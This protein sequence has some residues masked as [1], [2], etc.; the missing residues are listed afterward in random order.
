MEP[1]KW[2]I[3]HLVKWLI[4]EKPA[5]GVPLCNF[6]RIRAI[7]KPCDV[8]LVEGRSK[9]SSLIKIFTKSPW[10]HAALFIGP[11][12]QISD[13]TTRKLIEQH[14]D[15]PPH[16]LLI[17]EALMDRGVVVSDF[18]KVY[19]CHHLRICRPGG[20]FPQDNTKVVRFA[21]EHLGCQYAFRYLVDIVRFLFPYRIIPLRWGSRLYWHY[22]RGIK[23]T[24]CSSMLARAFMSVSFPIIPIIKRND[25]GDLIMFRRNFRTMTP[26]DFDVSPYFEIVKYPLLSSN[27]LTD[28]RNLPWNSEGMVCNTHGDCFIPE[29]G[30]KKSPGINIGL[31]SAR[32]GLGTMAARLSQWHP[33]TLPHFNWKRL[34]KNR[35]DSDHNNKHLDR[36][37]V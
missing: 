4:R 19:G 34:K 14:Y 3:D 32:S 18:Q 25:T 12:N 31:D 24:V 17:I 6:R 15:G 7:I 35:G 10:S 16:R 21:A 27:D 13:P 9:S 36:G 22:K 8:V 5:A 29:R 26:R 23:K 2:I 33:P 30:G 20:L 11:L 37:E 28:Y 1:T